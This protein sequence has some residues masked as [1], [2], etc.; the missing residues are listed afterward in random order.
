[1]AL[2][3]FN[4]QECLCFWIK[5]LGSGPKQQLKAFIQGAKVILQASQV[6]WLMVNSDVEDI[7]KKQLAEA[8]LAIYQQATAPVEA[9]MKYLV[10]QTAPFADCPPVAT[11]G[12]NV[13]VIANR[14]LR[15]VRDTEWEIQQYSEAI[16]INQASNTY[17]NQLLANLDDIMDAI[18]NC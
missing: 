4:D 7:Y 9:A 12:Q 8:T 17:I 6:I 15:D 5:N 18:D 3:D 1:M 16:A 11:L 10:N 13:K 14:V 2:S